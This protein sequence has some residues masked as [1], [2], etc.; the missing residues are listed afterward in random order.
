MRYLIY[1]DVHWCTYSS[2]IRSRGE[3]YSKRI[4]NLITST[5]WAENLAVEKACNEIICLGDFFDK[6]DL[7]SEELTSIMEIKWANLPHHFIV[8][9]H[10]ASNKSLNYNSVNVLAKN[11]FE[12]I[13]EVKVVPLTGNTY[14]LYIPYLQDDVR[15]SIKEYRQQ[16]NI[17]S[18]ARVIVLSHNDVKG[19]QYGPTISKSG[20]E[21]EDIENSCNIFLNGHIHNGN[22]ICKNGFNLGNLTGK[23]FEENAFLY[24]HCALILDIVN[25]EINLEF[26]ENPYA[27]NFYQLEIRKVEDL[28]KLDKLKNH[29]IVSIKYLPELKSDVQAAVDAHKNIEESKLIRI[30]EF[31]ATEDSGLVKLADMNHL[32][33][34]KTFVIAEL[35]SSEMLV[36]ELNRIVR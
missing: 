24:N 3:T 20:I 21:L 27:F 28:S 12:I 31:K 10:D 5:N 4:E 7:T 36:E 29:A 14:L 9:N 15:L 13:K 33:Q 30:M 35:G 16:F 22:K 34:F 25:D 19:I 2:I 11:G 8:G 17:P 6:P 1:T 26:I 23:I 18:D 32:D